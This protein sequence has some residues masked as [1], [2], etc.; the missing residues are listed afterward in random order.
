MTPQLWLLFFR[1]TS[2][3]AGLDQACRPRG[4]CRDQSRPVSMRL[5]RIGRFVFLQ[6]AIERRLSD[7]KKLGCHQLVPIH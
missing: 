7:P 3:K 2:H 5:P 6:L 1:I 4:I